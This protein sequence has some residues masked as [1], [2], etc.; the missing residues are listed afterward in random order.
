MSATPGSSGGT[1]PARWPRSGSC[2]DHLQGKLDLPLEFAGERHLKN[3]DRPVR[4]YRVRLRL[5]GG[6]ATSP[7]PRSRRRRWTWPAAAAALLALVLAA[8][9]AW[10]LRPGK[11]ADAGRPSIAVLPFDNYGG[12]EVTGRLADGI[13]EG[14][15][16]D[17]A[18][19]RDRG[20]RGQAGRRAPGRD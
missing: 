15:I 3:I 19:F 11:P 9:A 5:E 2:G 10:W 8:G 12:D 16:T 6:R 14:V 20:L 7:P 1:R 17:L 13:T 4:A 18:R